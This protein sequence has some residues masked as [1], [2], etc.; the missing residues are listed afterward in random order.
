MSDSDVGISLNADKLMAVTELRKLADKGNADAQF[1]LGTLYG[2]ADGVPLDRDKAMN[3]FMAAAKQGH[4]SAVITIAWMYATGSGVDQN[5]QKARELY[6]MAANHG[7]AKAQYVVATMYR[8][9]QHGLDRDMAKALEFYMKAA[10][11]GLS[12]A[13]LA[14]GKLLMEGKSVEKDNVVALQWL[15]LAHVNGSKRAEEIIEELI[16]TMEPEEVE[17]ARAASVAQ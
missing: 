13:Q 14:L 3:Y 12:S 9:A 1:K 2:N 15:S 11:Q 4:E 10:D 8:F 5:D 7:S 17:R 6:L 16:K